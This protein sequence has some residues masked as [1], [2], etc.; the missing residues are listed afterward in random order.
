VI[1]TAA[2]GGR[3][4]DDPA[5]V[6]PSVR[7]TLVVPSTPEVAAMRPGVSK[8]PTPSS[9][10]FEVI[11]GQ[12]HV[13]IIVHHQRLRYP[14]WM[15]RMIKMHHGI[16]RFLSSVTLRITRDPQPADRID[17]MKGFH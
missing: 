9:Q 17:T 6:A 13:D 3:I 4:S 1:N 11:E 8:P 10:L 5:V 14:A 12:P 15:H 7:E 16:T 2:E